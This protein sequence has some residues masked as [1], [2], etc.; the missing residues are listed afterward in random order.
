MKSYLVNHKSKN[1]SNYVIELLMQDFG[2]EC[3]SE[4]ESDDEN[5]ESGEDCASDSEDENENS[6]ANEEWTSSGE[7][8]SDCSESDEVDVEA[9]AEAALKKLIPYNV[10]EF[11]KVCL[12]TPL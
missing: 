4:C 1:F 2:D 5:A 12:C 8:K 6:A 10:E 3:S 11:E 7:S 9:T